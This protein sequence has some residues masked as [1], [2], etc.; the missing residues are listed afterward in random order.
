MQV[1]DF[2][3]R[4]N[5]IS[6]AALPKVRGAIFHNLSLAIIEGADAHEWQKQLTEESRVFPSEIRTVQATLI[7]RAM[8][9]WEKF[10]GGYWRQHFDVI[11]AEK[12]WTWPITPAILQPLRL[13]KILRRKAD[14]RLGI[15]D[16]KTLGSVDPNWIQRL[17]LSDQTHLYVQALKERSGE[18]ILGICYDGIV[19]GKF[20]K[21]WHRSPFV[22]GYMKNGQVTTKYS[23]GAEAFDLTTYSDEKWWE[24]IEKQKIDLAELYP[25]TDFLHPPPQMLLHTK[26][27]TGL[28]EER[29]GSLTDLLEAAREQ[30]GESDSNYTYLLQSVEK[31]PEQCLKYGLDYACPFVQQCWRGFPVDDQ[32][33]PRIDHHGEESED[34]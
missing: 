17:E 32:F 31:N 25:T 28:A 29:W 9:G 1:K 14:R 6:Y 15:F 16:Y 18:S 10:R 12:E 4:D 23:S 34:E 3:K 24:W 8:L 20:S 19:I 30:Y 21:G 2:G 33:E 13:D 7:R 5:E 26:Y 22:M 11:S 27:A